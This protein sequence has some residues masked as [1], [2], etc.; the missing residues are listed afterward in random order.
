MYI[1]SDVTFALSAKPK[2]NSAKK[3]SRGGVGTGS[4]ARIV[5]VHPLSKSSL[6]QR[7]VYQHHLGE[8]VPERAWPQPPGATSQAGMGSRG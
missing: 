5:A 6:H 3:L 2:F 1:N 4:E 7:P 8:K